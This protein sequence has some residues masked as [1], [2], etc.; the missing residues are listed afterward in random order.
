MN[1]QDF[2]SNLKTQ[3]TIKTMADNARATM[4]RRFGGVERSHENKS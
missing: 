1:W 3:R 4:E 2:A